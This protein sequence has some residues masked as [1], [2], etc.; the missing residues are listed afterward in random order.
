MGKIF[1]TL[2]FIKMYNYFF[3]KTVV[4]FL[5]KQDIKF[6]QKIQEKIEILCA[7]PFDNPLDIKT[8]K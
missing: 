8:F 5:E 1:L 7:N 2:Y 4:K 3:S 6:N